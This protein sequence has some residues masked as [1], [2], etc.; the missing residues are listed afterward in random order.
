MIAFTSTGT[1][2]KRLGRIGRIAFAASLLVAITACSRDMSDLHSFVEKAKHAHKTPPPPLPEIRPHE[3]FKYSDN[4][5]R[6]P[7]AVIEFNRPAPGKGNGNGPRPIK[8]RPKEA[9][10]AYPLDSLRMVGTL[11]QGGAT[12]ALIKAS[13]GTIHRVTVGNY[14]GQNDGKITRITENEVDLMEIV[15]DGLGNGNYIERPASV[16]LSE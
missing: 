1:T 6:D 5:M 15:P 3:T 16:A 9:L 12:W 14:M 13:D 10:E 8:D 11:Q 4:K 2:A 7:F